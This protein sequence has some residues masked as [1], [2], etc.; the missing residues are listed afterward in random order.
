MPYARKS[1]MPVEPLVRAM[2]AELFARG[3]GD[4]GSGHP[5]RPES[6]RRGAD[7]IDPTLMRAYRRAVKRGGIAVVQAD[8]ICCTILST[9]PSLLWPEHY[10]TTPIVEPSSPTWFQAKPPSSGGTATR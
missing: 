9:H 8:R 6:N 3:Y 1:L 10:W 7:E 2:K 4:H 5:I